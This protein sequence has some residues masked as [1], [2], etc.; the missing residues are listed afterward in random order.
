MDYD[1]KKI[2][3]LQDFIE[4]NFDKRNGTT[5]SLAT[6][7]WLYVDDRIIETIP[8]KNTVEKVLYKDVVVDS[9][10]EYNFA[11]KKI[12]IAFGFEDREFEYAMTIAEGKNFEKVISI[13]YIENKE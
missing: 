6:A 5:M 12:I 1:F 13:D 11:D 9:E 7:L 2:N 4:Q 10:G 8:H 3:E